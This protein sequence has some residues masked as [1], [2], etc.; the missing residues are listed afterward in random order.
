MN[1]TPGQIARDQIDTAL[2]RSGW[3]LQNASEINR[4][5]GLRVAVREYRTNIGPAD[6]VLFVDGQAVGS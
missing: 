6:Y 2:T 3:L 1:Q 4:K 5:A